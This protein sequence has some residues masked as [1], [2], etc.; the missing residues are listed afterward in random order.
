MN[1]F[2]TENAKEF[3]SSL[4]SLH[5]ESYHF[6]IENIL[7]HPKWWLG[8]LL[9]IIPWVLWFIFRKKE[10]SFS[11][12]LSGF[13]VITISMLFDMI[14]SVNGF[15][16][17]HFETIPLLPSHLPFNLSLMPVTVMFLIQFKPK[18]NL[19]FKATLFAI[20]ASFIAE[21]LF[22]WMGIYQ[23]ILWKHIYSFSIN[24]VVYLIAFYLFSRN[25]FERNTNTV[26]LKG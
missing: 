3:Y 18:V 12:L 9:T 15:W 17:Y 16:I 13:F 6:W 5:K 20:L 8:V 26:L 11:F 21:P 23:P 4:N 2:Y 24:F 7:F 14:G 22:I 1:N 10:S 25:Q 19:Y